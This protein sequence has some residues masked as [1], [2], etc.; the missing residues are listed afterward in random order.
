[1]PAK[2]QIKRIVVRGTNWIGDAVM[3]IPALRELSRIFPDAEIVLHTKTSVEGLFDDADFI[4]RVMPFA[5]SKSKIKHTFDQADQLGDGDF[6][7]AV[8]FPNSFESAIT[9]KLAKIPH[10]IGYN[11]DLRGLLLTDP[12]AVPEWK[13]KRHEVFY[14]LNL[15]AEAERR[16]LG[17]SSVLCSLPDASLPVSEKRRTDARK[18]L[19][20]E[21]VD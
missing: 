6:D 19:E 20:T 5:K 9:T 1:M 17:T 18:M 13:D 12:V 16:Y 3:S 21:G 7:L 8:L 2:P 10:R 14:Y 4:D 11:K 15:V